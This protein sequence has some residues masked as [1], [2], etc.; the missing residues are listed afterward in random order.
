MCLFLGVSI[1]A[2]AAGDKDWKPISP[3][4]L[5]QKKSKVEADAD[6]EAMFWEVRV[7]D[8]SQDSLVLNHYIRVKI[9]TERGREQ[10]SKVDVEFSKNSRVKDVDARV[11]KSDGSITGL[12]PKDVF[13]RTIVK[14]GRLKVKAK[15]FAVPGI[16]PGVIIEYRWKQVYENAEA[17]LRL[18]FQR[19]VPMQSVSYSIK[20]YQGTRSLRYESF[21]TDAKFVKGKDGFYIAEMKNV[22]ALRNEPRMPPSDDIRSWMYIYYTSETKPDA[23]RFWNEIGKG[24]A[25]NVEKVAKPNDE[26]KAVAAQTIIGATTDE[27]KLA[28]LYEFCKTQ[29]K[30][31]SY[32]KTV[33]TDEERKKEKDNKNAADVLKRKSGSGADIDVL[34]FALAKSIGLDPHLALTGDRGEQRFSKNI[35]SNTA[36]GG[37]C[38][39]IKVKDKWQFFSPAE[40][41]TPFGML[42]WRDEGQE[43]LITDTKNPEW[44]QIPFSAPEKSAVKRFARFAMGEDGSLEGKVKIEY[45]GNWSAARKF[46]FDDDSQEQRERKVETEIRQR[47]NGAEITELKV[48][49]V[50]DPIKNFTISYKVKVPN[51]AQKTGKRLFFVPN[52][53][54]NGATA[55][56][57]GG[58]RR[59]PIFFEYPWSENDDIEIEFPTGF[60]LDSADAPNII[61]D[62]S[63]VT[64]DIIKIAVTTD[65]KKLIYKRNFFFG[66]NGNVLF[67]KQVYPQLKALFDEFQK[68]ETHSLALKQK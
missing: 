34:F 23:Q 55:Q 51:Y 16:E 60:A 45:T 66:N 5:A 42:S 35:A 58:E 9:F 59:Y 1:I 52:Y 46:Y 61:A 25:G 29:I 33:K 4:E 63:K 19:E 54:E 62:P 3:E 67:D 12:N 11:I 22:P 8:S 31:T 7:D 64:S 38:I 18:I 30:N 50:T 68:A 26:I 15:S 37:S 6:A 56:F 53:F 40:Q 41:Y 32:D 43:A 24:I 65:G 57:S 49:N 20:P 10:F 21:N 14:Q 39:A 2:N 13:E 44:V 36:L 48:E 28:K 27:E 47:A 17:N